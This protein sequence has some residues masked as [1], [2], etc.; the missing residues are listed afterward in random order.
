MPPAALMR[1]GHDIDIPCR[2]PPKCEATCLTHL[3]G[4][5]EP[6]QRAQADHQKAA[7]IKTAANN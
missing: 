5:L 3:N 2:V 4:V 6:S 1:P 7:Q